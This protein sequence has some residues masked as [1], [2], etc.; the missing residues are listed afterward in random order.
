VRGRERTQIWKLL[1][2]QRHGMLS[3]TSC[4]WFFDEPSGIETLQI[5]S[6]AARALQL[7]GECGANLEPEF[8]RRLQP[9]RSNLPAQQDGRQI[10][11]DLVRPQVAD[12]SRIVAHYA[13]SSIF[14]PPAADAR[15]YAYRVTSIDRV[16]E[17]AGAASFAIG[18]VRLTAEATEESEERVYAALHLG[19]HDLHCAV[20]P[21][22]TA[23]SYTQLK[24]ALRA[25]FL[26]EPLTELV[27]R[28]DAAFGAQFYTLRDVF[29]AE[30]R[31]ILDHV[32]ARAI[33]ECTADYERMFARNRR[34]LDFLAQA[35]VPVPE[36]LRVAAAFV[37][38]RRL[39]EA[40]A[41][42][43]AGAEA[44]PAVLALWADVHRW[45][46]RPVMAGVGQRLEAALAEVVGRIGDGEPQAAVAH[47]QAILVLAAEL[48]LTLN[49]WEA[50]NRYY[51]LVVGDGQRRWPGGV[52]TELRRLGERLGFCLREW[53]SMA[54]RAA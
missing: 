6:Y 1:E 26:T 22:G 47:A 7:A 39:E 16:A 2:M 4:G 36:E 40:T 50:Q 54:A 25:A 27:R 14:E 23:I 53:E 29:A 5:L 3:F 43:V 32:M 41:K 17:H 19:G 35:Y 20:A 51:R 9:M 28:I 21:E 8:L 31:R 30:R 42:F 38:Q 12:A 11:R 24:P 46:I 34:L 37:M 13:M 10:Y 18:R 52:L 33:A 48:H 45:R 44:A 15:T 49:T